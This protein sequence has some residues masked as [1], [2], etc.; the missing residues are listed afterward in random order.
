MLEA[1]LLG[2]HKQ[3]LTFPHKQRPL[4]DL[5]H[6]CTGTGRGTGTE[7][8]TESLRSGCVVSGSTLKGRGVDDGLKSSIGA[9]VL[10]D[11]K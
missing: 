5:T 9:N 1:P 2:R 4:I 8:G 7:T 3:L 10:E 6:G 11:P